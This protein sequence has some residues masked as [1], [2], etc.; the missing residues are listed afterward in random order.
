MTYKIEEIEGIGPA[1][2]NKLAEA[3][4]HTTEDLLEHCADKKGRKAISE[5]TGLSE[6]YIL[7]WANMADLM[8]INGVGRQYAELLEASGVD[9]VKELRT[10]NVDNLA[11]KMSEVNEEKNLAKSVPSSSMVAE[12]IEAA[13]ATEPKIS[14]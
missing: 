4:I 9:T 11:A 12:W 5:R 8:R 6:K 14:Y 2:G 10:R 1:Y 3:G 7:T 13:K